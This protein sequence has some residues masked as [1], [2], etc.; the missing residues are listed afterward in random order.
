MVMVSQSSINVSDLKRL[1]SQPPFTTGDLPGTGGVLKAIPEHFQVEE[2]L[3]YEPCG[4][5]EHVF[6]RL[7][8]TGWNTADVAS[9]LGK[10]FGLK[11]RYRLGG[12][13]G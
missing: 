3:P 5:G 8:R 10:V 12:T 2:V 1:I 7:R 6:V 9:A 4:E 11:A 13:K